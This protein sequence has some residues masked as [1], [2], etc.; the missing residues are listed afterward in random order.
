MCSHPL[1][2]E[3]GRHHH[4]AIKGGIEGSLGECM[5]LIGDKLRQEYEVLLIAV[6]VLNSRVFGAASSVKYCELK[7]NIK[8]AITAAMHH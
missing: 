8:Y 2:K 6:K 4:T 7:L 5:A 3:G 1:E